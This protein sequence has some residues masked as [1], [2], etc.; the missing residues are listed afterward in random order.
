MDLLK[1]IDETKKTYDETIKQKNKVQEELYG[2]DANIKRLEGAFNAYVNLAQEEGIIDSNGNIIK[3]EGE[4][5][6]STTK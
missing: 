3:K 1:K 6:G 4:T 5:D 2:L